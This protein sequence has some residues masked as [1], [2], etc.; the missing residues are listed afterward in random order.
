MSSVFDSLVGMGS[1]TPATPPTDL[2][3]DFLEGMSLHDMLMLRGK[4]DDRL[5]ARALKDLDLEEEAVVQYLTLKSLQEQVLSQEDTAANQ[6]AQVANA[7]AGALS[8]L[9]KIQKEAYTFERFKEVENALVEMLKEWPIEQM[10]VF[11][12]EYERRLGVKVDLAKAAT[13]AATEPT[14]KPQEGDPK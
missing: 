8:G 1:S 12:E 5:P 2:Q 4:I 7:T 13:E 9:L 14:P 10:Q 3:D 11:F 6:K